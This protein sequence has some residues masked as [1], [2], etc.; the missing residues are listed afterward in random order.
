MSEKIKVLIVDD[1]PLFRQGLRQVVE[2][3]SRFDLVAEA[4]DGE[5]ALRSIQDKSPDVAVLDVDL[6]RLSGLEVAR[7]LQGKGLPTRV[8]I[9][10][11]YKEEEI[12]NRALDFGVM[13]FVLKENAVEDILNSVVAVA[14]G[15]HYLS[16]TISGYLLRR[17]GR[18]EELA[19]KKPGLNDLTKAERRILKLI[20]EKKTS[21][22]IAMELSISQRTV[23]AHRAH[24]SA[25]LDLH[26][27]HS[28]LQFALE[29]RTAV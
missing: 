25:K 19:M 8:I 29:N 4:G 7:A 5:T 3:D 16:S 13:G 15:K 27:N 28:L 22:E 21:R 20:A 17:L 11:M 6:P 9:L 2:A 10:T 1:H 12:F 24:I 14:A 18:A 26:G 23:D